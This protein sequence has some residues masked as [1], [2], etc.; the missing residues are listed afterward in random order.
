MLSIPAWSHL[1]ILQ[2]IWSVAE[3]E[4]VGK[5][6]VRALAWLFFRAKRLT[7]RL[8]RW[9]RFLLMPPLRWFSGAYSRHWDAATTA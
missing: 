8:P 6:L 7:G 3:G 2:G 5:Y 9:L 1:P 4:A